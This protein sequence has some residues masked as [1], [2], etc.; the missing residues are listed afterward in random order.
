MVNNIGTYTWMYKSQ[1]YS[2]QQCNLFRQ[3]DG[4][5]SIWAVKRHGEAS[6]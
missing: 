6:I 2:Q 4:H 5:V 1:H 3:C